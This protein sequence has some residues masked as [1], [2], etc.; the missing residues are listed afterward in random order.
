MKWIGQHIW[1]F[2]SRFRNDVYLESVTESTQ[3]HVVG[4]DANGKLYK[5]DVSTGDITGVTITTD[6]GG[7]SAAS[8]TAG[9]ADFS[10]LGSTGVGV[11]NSGTTITAT[12]VPAEIDHDSL[13][14]FVAAEHYAWASDI[15]GTAT[16]HANNIT[17]LHGAGVD[18][19]ANQLLTDDG[20][21]SITS[22]STLT[23]NGTSLTAGDTGSN[24][25]TIKR[26]AATSLGGGAMHIQGGDGTAGQTNQDGGGV[27]LRGGIGTGSGVGGN[28]TVETATPGSSGTSLNSRDNTWTF[29]DNGMFTTANYGIREKVK[30]VTTTFEDILADGD[31]MSSKVLIYGADESLTDGQVYFLH[32][33]NS[34]DQADASAVATGASQLLGIGNGRTVSQGVILEGFVRIP[35]TEILNTPGS[36]AVDGLPVYV[37]TTAGH[38]DFTAPSGNNEFVRVVGYA[39]DDDSSDVLVYFNPDRTWVK[40]TT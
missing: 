28:V 19:S 30:L 5:Q 36:G 7:G 11:T 8:D 23:W 15:S 35:S 25:N 27:S 26:K 31:H 2:I 6:S 34:W 3:D 38:L 39:I 32:T 14:N 17:D 18:G 33:D 4:I 24:T 10:I 16:I 20:D 9:S 21:G 1:D 37:S 22:E 13:S 29:D 12:A 40:V